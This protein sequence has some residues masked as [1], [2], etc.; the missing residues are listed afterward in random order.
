MNRETTHARRLVTGTLAQQAA[1]AVSVISS[2]VVA[3]ALGRTLSLAEFGVWGL[4]LSLV[5]YLS[6]VQGGLAAAAVREISR[7]RS[8]IAR[9]RAFTTAFIMRA[10]AGLLIG[11]VLALGG[12]ALLT[13]FNLPP[14]LRDQA[15]AGVLVLGAIMAAGSPAQAFRDVLEGTQRFA[16]FALAQ[17]AAGL[18]YAG[19]MLVLVLVVEP[20]LW[21]LIATSGLLPAGIGLMCAGVVFALRLPFRMRPGV[22]ER[23]YVRRFATFS[24]SMLVIGVTEVVIF[25][26]DRA[27]LAAF[28]SAAT[29][30]LYEAAVRP[31]NLMRMFQGALGI[32]VFPASASFLADRDTA[33]LRQLLLRGTRYVLAA[34]AP[35]SVVLIVLS[36]PILDVWL[37]AHF[38]EAAPAM[39]I[40][41]GSWLLN[42]GVAVSASMVLAVGRVKALIAYTSGAALLNLCL[43]L[44]LTPA[45]G[46]EGVAIGTTGAFLLTF[47]LIAAITTRAIPVTIRDLAERAWFPAYSLAG[48]LAVMLTVVRL[49][50]DLDSL[51]LLLAVI[52]VSLV[53][54]W[55]AYWALWLD[56][57]ERS[58]VRQLVPLRRRLVRS[59]T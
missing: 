22:L 29:V 14:G 32:T 40:L 6:F 15:K 51:A 17:A 12:L 9:D 7:A 26:L 31:S 5:G 55:S 44:A 49:S 38:R 4:T 58:L 20:P 8:D 28:H 10:V 56:P 35:V 24:G 25:Q 21:V 41:V 19:T 34:T 36:A 57:G 43:S 54:Y 18:A 59:A 50:F 23:R 27:V 3:T 2:L 52:T 39:S 53:T 16:L 11:A 42:S 48:G 45:L 47:P 33:R 1:Q 46:L 13:I 30:G 37:G